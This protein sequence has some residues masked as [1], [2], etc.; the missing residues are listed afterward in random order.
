MPFDD[1]A[2]QHLLRWVQDGV[3][4]RRQLLDLGAS[5]G[6]IKRMVRRRELVR[7]HPGVF[8]NH[9]GEPSRSQREQAAVLACWPAALG[10]ESAMG[11]P[12][13]DGR[14]R[15]VIPA[16]RKVVPLRGVR[17]QRLDHF[18]DRVDPIPSPPAVHYSHAAIDTAAERDE[19]AAFALLSEALW[20]RRTTV[21]QLRDVLDRRGR[22]RR[23]SMLSRLLEDLAVGTCSVLERGYLHRVEGPHGL[24]RMDRQARDVLNGRTIYRDGEYAA[25]RLVIELDGR[26]HHTGAAARTRDSTRDLETLADR[27]EATVRLTYHQVFKDSCRTARLIARIL[28]HRGWTGRTHRCPEC[29]R[30]TA[31]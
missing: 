10:F 26:V 6:D 14:I 25:Y 20:T 28:E 7:M 4:S 8:I 17:V 3:V 15:V 16:G 5:D 1:D 19:A 9:T 2:L 13:P 24:P 12:P 29:P 30:A 23:R 11:V 27:D 21:T 31:V 18:A 22:I